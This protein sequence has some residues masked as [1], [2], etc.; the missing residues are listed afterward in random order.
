[1][2]GLTLRL[3]DSILLAEE[4][5]QELAEFLV[6]RY[7]ALYEVTR[8]EKGKRRGNGWGGAGQ[9][10][11]ITIV[12]LEATYDL[13][14]E[15]PLK[16]ANLLYVLSTLCFDADTELNFAAYKRTGRS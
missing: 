10:K 6:R 11:T 2:R 1:M 5:V 4:L 7:P 3:S 12:P 8:H 13:Q 14:N 15:D 16:V 9:I